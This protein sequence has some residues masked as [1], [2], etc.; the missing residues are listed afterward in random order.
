[1]VYRDYV[2]R[3]PEGDGAERV[4]QRFAGLMTAREQPRD[5]LR[6]TRTE[7]R[8]EQKANWDLFGGISQYYR[9]DVN[10]TDIDNDDDK[11]T[12]VSQSSLNNNMDSTGRLRTG[13]YDL[14]TR[15]TGGYLHDF[16]D[17]GVNSDTTVSSMYF[18][19][20]DI[21]TH[22]S[23]RIGRQSRSTG[24]V[25]GRFD[26]LLL[27]FPLGSKFSVSAVGGLPVES[28]TDAL[29]D[30][31]KYFYGLTLETEE[32]AK[33]WDAN[34]F[35]IERHVDGMTDRR[36]VGG[37]LRY[38]DLTRSFFSLVDYDI[39]HS[40]LNIWQLLGN[41][42]LPDKTTVNLVANYR[43]SPI[44]MTSNA[45]TGQNVNSIED[46][47]DSFSSSEIRD[48]A[49]DRTA[50]SKLATLGVSRP[51]NEKLQISG[52]ITA[53]KISG[54]NESGGIEA[55]E[56]TGP[57]YVYNV[58]LIG[59]NLIKQGDITIFGLRYADGDDR[60]IY[61]LNFN[62]RFPVTRDFRVNPRFRIDYRKNRDDNTDQMIYRPSLR[63]SYRV[64]RRLRL[65]AEIGGE[66]SDREI[67]DG[68]QKDGSY[69]VN[70]GYRADF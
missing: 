5:K 7:A 14:R 60:D 13:N 56:G 39:H 40:K 30:T 19:A 55:M 68:S 20:Q 18:D 63:L 10:T 31:N 38:F 61:S 3:Y 6:T 64:K 50:T 2:E 44:L 53:L 27:G 22:S 66:Y 65:E 46:L 21:Q 69:F 43:K 58:Q 15:F 24:G 48:L 41:W 16:L 8:A 32:F 57:D 25:L 70:L 9:R 26:G 54:T 67:V 11:L 33:G 29:D 51:M 45:L 17:N 42:T 28:S 62:T 59:S 52:D 1:M 35:V 12:T 23:M 49:R 47:Q 36:A 34:T 4:K 37:E